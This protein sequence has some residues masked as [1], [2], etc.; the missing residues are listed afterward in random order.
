MTQT[1][2]SYDIFINTHSGTVLTVGND[3][4]EREITESRLPIR[5]LYILPAEQLLDKLRHH[6]GEAAILVGGGDGTVRSC[7]AVLA[8][9]GLPFGIL[10]LGTMNLLARDL[11]I[12]HDIGA[13][14]NAYA[15]GNEAVKIDTATVNGETFLCSACLGGIPEASMVREKHRGTLWPLLLPRL[16]Y[17]LFKGMNKSARRRLHLMLD[18][19]RKTLRTAAL[20]VANNLYDTEDCWGPD[21]LKRSTLDCGHLGVYA[22]SPAG[23]WDKI[24]LLLRLGIGGWQHDRTMRMWKGHTLDIRTCRPREM[25]TL[26]GET[27]AFDMP[28]HFE[29]RPR[30]LSLLVPAVS[31]AD[32]K[33]AA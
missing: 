10:P 22:A 1:G 17:N 5:S 14:L 31:A 27:E 9:R 19:R 11:S 32:S 29:V 33:K 7:A 23:L 12:P 20:V 25:L 8:A 24:R 2:Q 6:D 21:N 16:I 28:L 15:A 13:A 30:A 4:L 26:D 18:G 3:A